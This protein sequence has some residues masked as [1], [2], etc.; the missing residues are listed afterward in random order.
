MLLKILAWPIAALVALIGIEA[1]TFL[2]TAA[3]MI[4][5]GVVLQLYGMEAFI[6]LVAVIVV[7][8][9]WGERRLGVPVADMSEPP[10]PLALPGAGRPPGLPGPGAQAR[11]SSTR[12]A[13]VIA[14]APL[15]TF[16]GAS[17]PRDSGAHRAPSGLQSR[18]D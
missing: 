2:G 6:A 12:N 3:V 9:L 15:D 7:L 18:P 4:G 14:S 17:G 1:F 13:N 5:L 10:E 11:L 16:R 8:S